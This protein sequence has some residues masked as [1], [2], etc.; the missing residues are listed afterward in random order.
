MKKLITVFL[1]LAMLLSLAACGGTGNEPS[2]NP[3]GS[4]DVEA[5]TGTEV[6]PSA[7]PSTAPSEEPSTPPS[8]EPS[9][10][11]E[12]EPSVEPSEPP[13]EE[14]PMNAAAADYFAKYG[15][16]LPPVPYTA[17]SEERLSFNDP[18][19]AD[20]LEDYLSMLADA[21]Y[22]E[23]TEHE[24]DDYG[25][26]TVYRVCVRNQHKS[27]VSIYLETGNLSSGMLD[28]FAH[29]KDPGVGGEEE[30]PASPWTLPLPEPSFQFITSGS[31]Y[32]DFTCTYD[33][34]NAYIQQLIAS[35]IKY[36]YLSDTD[37]R[38]YFGGNDGTGLQIG[39]NFYKNGDQSYMVIH[40]LEKAS[41]FGTGWAENEFERLFVEPPFI[42]QWVKE[43]T[44]PNTYEMEVQGGL[45]TTGE[46]RAKLLD[47]FR[48]LCSYGFHIEVTGS[49]EGADGQPWDY[50]WNVTDG[51]G[52]SI[53][54]MMDSGW[55]WITVH[56]GN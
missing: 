48:I 11:P 28:F 51:H 45:D 21:G 29:S 47:Y 40:H 35:G 49:V 32:A 2:T 25:Q 7:E 43:Q 27:W 38:L 42:T 44:G 36:Y 39:F 15:M 1:T 22:T 56:K 46:D 41:G 37:D 3:G 10:E 13:V 53:E 8:E 4:P 24:I 30:E 17:E 23:I 16:P 50:E 26:Y 31:D 55:C 20:W 54:F 12:P 34:A 52:N 6:P 33:E 5:S 18:V 19:T 9:A 14:N